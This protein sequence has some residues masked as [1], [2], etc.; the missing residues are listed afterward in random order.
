MRFSRPVLASAGMAAACALTPAVASAAPRADRALSIHATP[1]HVIAGDPVLIFGHLSGPHHADREITLYHRVGTAPRFT[2]VSRTRTNADG[3]YFFPRAQSV[4]TTDRSWF[5]R[6]PQRS[7][8]TTIRETVAA[9]VT[10]AQST[11]AA[12]TRSPIR[13]TGVVTPAR[14]GARVGLQVQTGNGNTWRTVA[15]G[16]VGARGHFSI[17]QAW[18][19]PGPRTVRA[20]FLG[21]AVNTRAASSAL[22]VVV[23]QRQ[24]PRFTIHTSDAVISDG[25]TATISGV[26]DS[27]HTTAGQAGVTV[28]LYG[29]VPR[30][31]AAFS[32]LQTVT[33][34]AG[35]RYAFTV[36]GATNELYQVR[37]V[38]TPARHTALLF[39]G[40]Q[41]AVTITPSAMSARV[42]GQ[43]TFTGA[44]APANAGQPVM[45]EY[46][47]R[48]GHWQVATT[49]TV[50]P[51]STYSIP[52]TFGAEGI[53]HFRVRVAGGT[54]NVGGASAPVTITVA[55]PTLA[56][57]PAS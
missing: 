13:F 17:A 22:A 56:S 51:N 36:A 54:G 7:H 32:L 4:V 10:L 8:S 37:V 47:G 18:R 50:L 35:G 46:L 21:D 29:R 41:D 19:T 5:V 11:A 31:G 1:S 45:L 43:V 48:D 39:Q 34:G 28:G 25:Q 57:L 42:G 55:Q 33:T 20:I 44:V 53:K 26:L 9:E 15:V 24:A 23:S 52:W 6:G 16:R 38:G 12:T 49:S 27:P 30:T 3:K 14:A 2:V 40:V